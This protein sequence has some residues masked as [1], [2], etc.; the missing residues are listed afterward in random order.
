[1]NIA[2][3]T[4]MADLLKKAKTLGGEQ[5]LGTDAKPKAALVLIEAQASGLDLLSKDSEKKDG[6]DKFYGE[7]KKGQGSKQIHEYG[8]D[9]DKVNI[10]KFRA[11]AKA[12]HEGGAHDFRETADKLLAHRKAELNVGNPVQGAFNALVNAARVQAKQETALT[13]A[14]IAECVAKAAHEVTVE[15]EL[16][17]IRKAIERVVTGENKHGIKDQHENITQAHDLIRDRLAMFVTARE[18][19]DVRA[20]AAALGWTLVE[21]SVE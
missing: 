14:Q 11:C 10:S 6:I 2:N 19:T 16:E 5:A 21:T 13:D 15:D 12:V 8:K 3:D 9:G 1:M 17:R 20:K 7:Y 18:Q 4:R